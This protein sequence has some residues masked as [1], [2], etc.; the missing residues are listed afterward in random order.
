MNFNQIIRVVE[1][2]VCM[3]M[4]NIFPDNQ[5]LIYITNYALEEYACV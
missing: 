5:F 3:Y 4:Y 1:S 2:I